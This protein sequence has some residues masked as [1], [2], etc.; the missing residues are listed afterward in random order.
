MS[1]IL[2][3]PYLT[4]FALFAKAVFLLLKDVVL[5]DEICAAEKS[6][7]ICS[8]DGQALWAECNDF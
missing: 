4:H 6:L 3:R 8:A 1:D 5:E 2:P 7:N